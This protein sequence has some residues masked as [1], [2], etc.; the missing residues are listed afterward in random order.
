MVYL[1]TMLHTYIHE[2]YLYT[3][4]TAKYFSSI[5][6]QI[7][8][9]YWKKK[10]L[11]LTL[12]SLFETRLP[13][14]LSE[15]CVFILIKLHHTRTK[16]TMHLSRLAVNTAF[17]NPIKSGLIQN[18]AFIAIPITSYLLVSNTPC[19]LLPW[20]NLPFPHSSPFWVLSTKLLIQVSKPFLFQM[21]Y[22]C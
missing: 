5:T 18:V 12:L 8:W 17:I 11:P 1:C 9:Y 3:Y 7:H 22:T 15:K 20:Y 4:G 6:I 10:I 16:H 21:T 19:E 13:K 14:Y 2:A